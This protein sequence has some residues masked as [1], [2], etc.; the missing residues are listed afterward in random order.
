MYNEIAK[1]YLSKILF[2]TKVFLMSNYCEKFT[3]VHKIASYEIGMEENFRDF[4]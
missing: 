1:Y 3:F 2:Y 4:I